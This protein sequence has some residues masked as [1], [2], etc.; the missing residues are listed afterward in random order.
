MAAAALVV[1]GVLAHRYF[2]ILDILDIMTVEAGFTHLAFFGLGGGVAVA[3]GPVGLLV[4]GRMVMAIIAG[5]A[6][7]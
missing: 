5:K 6:V 4:E 7:T 2:G 3:A 1:E